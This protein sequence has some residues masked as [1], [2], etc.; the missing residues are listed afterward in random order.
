[1]HRK[2][3]GTQPGFLVIATSALLVDY[4]NDPTAARFY[5]DNAVVYVCVSITL[6]AIFGGYFAIRDTG[7][8]QHYANANVFGIFIGRYTLAN[9]VF[10][11]TWPGFDA[12]NAADCSGCSSN[13]TANNP[14]NRT[15][16]PLTLPRTF[17]STLNGALGVNC[18][19]R[20]YCDG[21][22]RCT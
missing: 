16:S 21:Q 8:R 4:L 22:N 19:A 13:G 11:K 18:R 15:S 9:Y 20:K 5:D 1:M 7:F 2:K 3:P 12:E 6:N 17:R 14:S 10:A